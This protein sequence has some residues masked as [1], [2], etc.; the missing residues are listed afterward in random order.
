M[1]DQ[2]DT[3]N[4]ALEKLAYYCEDRAQFAANQALRSRPGT[5]GSTEWIREAADYATVSRSLRARASEQP[6][7]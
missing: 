1:S 4:L 7:C 5:P 2:T 6:P 3:R